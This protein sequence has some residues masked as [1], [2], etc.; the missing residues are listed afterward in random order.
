MFAVVMAQRVTTLAIKPGDLH[1][2][3]RT[4]WMERNNFCRPPKECTQK[5]I[6]ILSYLKFHSSFAMDSLSCLLTL[7]GAAMQWSYPGLCSQSTVLYFLAAGVYWISDA[8]QLHRV[9]EDGALAFHSGMDRHLLHFH[10]GDREDERGNYFINEKQEGDGCSSYLRMEN[11]EGCLGSK[12]S[13]TLGPVMLLR[14]AAF[15]FVK[16]GEVS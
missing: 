13:P 2:I 3:P 12:L 11:R 8:L 15:L 14:A 1:S 16:P 6:N 4:W 7:L 10:P 5:Y 9:S